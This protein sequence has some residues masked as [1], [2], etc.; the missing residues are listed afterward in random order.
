MPKRRAHAGTDAE[1]CELVLP[2]QDLDAEMAT[3]G[4]MML[5]RQAVESVLPIIPAECAHWFYRPAHST[6]FQALTSLYFDEQPIDLVIVVNHLKGL[7]A[8]TMERIGGE[9]YILTLV[10]SVGSWVN[11]AYYAKIVRDKGL[12]RDLCSLAGQVRE[13]SYAMGADP[14]A[15]ATKFVSQTDKL[16]RLGS[17]IGQPVSE[18][19][20]YRQMQNPQIM[21]E[22][23]VPIRLGQLGVLL[24]GGL[25]PGTL[26]LVGA[27]TS[28]GKTTFAATVC[29]Q[30]SCD[31][32]N[33]CS[34]L[35]VSA[36]MFKPQI[37]LRM[38]AARTG[39][40]FLNLRRG[41][42]TDDEFAALR[43]Q[44]AYEADQRR[45]VYLVDRVRDVQTIAAIARQTVRQSG[46][47]LVVVDFL[48]LLRIGGH[49]ERDD[50]RLGAIVETVRDLATD[51]GVAV[52]LLSQ[53]RRD[54][55]DPSKPPSLRDFKG[56]GVAE[57]DADYAI[58]LWP[59]PIWTR[60][61]RVIL[62]KQRQGPRGRV[63]LWLDPRSMMF[64][65]YDPATA[66]EAPESE[67]T[68]PVLF[69]AEP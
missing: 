29:L 69:G 67:E 11:A 60:P 17:D 14:G 66:G 41:H 46:V 47:R 19:E 58:L 57:E 38:M 62:A 44:A 40:H 10:E 22:G 51:T 52:M 12:L 59:E 56:T 64:V 49:F 9:D 7:G 68:D 28:E 33:A 3:L 6:L 32:T 48:Q 31:E 8:E 55:A 53:L 24:S 54:A 45:L 30:A 25:D 37:G 2:P 1:Q 61:C 5:D 26:T 27:R 18:S 42:M 34:S 43:D 63:D 39:A 15:I 50:L 20:V 13:E 16:I 23:R 65:D 4:S 21:R 35:F 36:E